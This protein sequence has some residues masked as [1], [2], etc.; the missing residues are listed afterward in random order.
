[1]I[2]WYPQLA[3]AFVTRSVAGQSLDFILF[4][5]LGFLCYTAYNV[6]LYASPLVRAEYKRANDG[7]APDVRT[8]DVFFACHALLC[9]L[10]GAA[11]ALRYDRGGHALSAP[12][13]ALSGVAGAFVL[14]YTGAWAA[15]ACGKSALGLVYALGY[16]KVGTSAV[17]YVPQLYHNA[18][19]RSTVGFNVANASTDAVG[20]A[21][22]LAQQ[23]LDAAIFKDASIFFGNPAKLALAALSL[24]Y[25]CGLMVQHYCLYT[26]RGDAPSLAGYERVEAVAV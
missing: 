4:N 20:G 24:C 14:A 10:L 15:G 21:L 23:A 17:K 13:L 3:T 8:N 5:L 6:A 25:D 22:S 9:T 7:V 12:A 11:Q 1:M 16:V 18:R 19:R 2:G 26:D